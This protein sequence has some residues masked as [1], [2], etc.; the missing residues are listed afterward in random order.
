LLIKPLANGLREAVTKFAIVRFF[1]N[2]KHAMRGIGTQREL[3]KL[4][5][6]FTDSLHLF[7]AANLELR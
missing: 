5:I 1:A 3:L 4:T 6:S 7:E 2:I